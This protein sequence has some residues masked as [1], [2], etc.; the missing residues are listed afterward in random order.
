MARDPRSLAVAQ[1]WPAEVAALATELWGSEPDSLSDL[2]FRNI[3]NEVALN[4][5]GD[6]IRGARIAAGDAIDLSAAPDFASRLAQTGASDQ[7]VRAF[8]AGLYPEM[9][10]ADALRRYQRDIARASG[11][12]VAEPPTSPFGRPF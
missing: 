2:E 11:L 1:T 9:S 6:V 7:D 12:T 10:A 8:A 3:A 4:H 5:A